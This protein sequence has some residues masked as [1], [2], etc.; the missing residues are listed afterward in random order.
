MS[1]P[2]AGSD[3]ASMKAEAHKTQDGYILNGTKTWCTHGGMADM[4]VVFA[5]T[6]PNAGS[7]GI[8][9]FLILKDDPGFAVVRDEDLISVRGSPQSTL[10]ILRLFRFGRPAPRRGGRGI[11]DRH[12][13]SRRSAAQRERQGP[14]SCSH[15]DLNRH[16]LCTG[17]SGVRHF[18]RQSPGSSVSSCGSRDGVCGCSDA[19]AARHRRAGT[20]S[21][22]EG[23]D[24]RLQWPSSRAP[25]SG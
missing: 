6:D 13:G 10:E 4:L 21:I 9:A 14:G 15:L 22:A 16:E 19:L 1:E 3:A 23:F 7:A 11:Q 20:A 25:K 5:K 24:A 17:S 8:S 18:D 12:E 2:S